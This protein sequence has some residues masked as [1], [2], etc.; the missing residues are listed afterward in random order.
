[1]KKH[2]HLTGMNECLDLGGRN[3]PVT[4]SY[5]T[6]SHVVSPYYLIILLLSR[7]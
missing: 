3:P 7:I 6:F 4:L 2:R 1:M 5:S